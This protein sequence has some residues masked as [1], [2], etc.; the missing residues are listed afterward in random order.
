MHV[1]IVLACCQ[2][3][4]LITGVSMCMCVCVCV[5]TIVSLGVIKE[6]DESDARNPVTVNEV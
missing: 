1:Y 2:S 6:L 5:V 4:D 3:L